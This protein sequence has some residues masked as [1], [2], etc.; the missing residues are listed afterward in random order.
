[1]EVI[2]RN[3][4]VFYTFIKTAVERIREKEKVKHVNGFQHKEQCL[5]NGLVRTFG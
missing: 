2:Y 5:L 4:E 3:D 1:M